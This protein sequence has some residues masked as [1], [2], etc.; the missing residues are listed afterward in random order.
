MVIRVRTDGSSIGNP[1]AGWWWAI[2]DTGD[3]EKILVGHEDK[4]T[5]NRMELY[6]VIAALAYL[7][8]LHIED[9][10]KSSRGGEVGLFAREGSDDELV[11]D[12]VIVY[13]DSM[14]VQKGITQW[15]S[16]WIERQRRLSR[17][18]KRVKNADLWQKLHYLLWYFSE[19]DWQRVRWHAGDLMNERVDTL[20]R[21]AAIKK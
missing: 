3:E 14:Y 12:Q 7:A 9:I 11:A 2:I 15:M 10:E 5:N 4:T 19:I 13:T 21:Q 1:G 8:G 20:A 17:G 6:A 18:G 16:R